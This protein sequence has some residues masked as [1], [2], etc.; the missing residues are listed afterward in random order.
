MS[1]VVVW[2]RYLK[3]V[4]EFKACYVLALKQTYYTIVLPV[5]NN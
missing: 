4:K 1:F 3:H 2:I 5:K